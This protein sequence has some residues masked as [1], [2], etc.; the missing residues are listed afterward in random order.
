[1]SKPETIPAILV[2]VHTVIDCATGRPE[3]P[4]KTVRMHA[5]QLTD[6]SFVVDRLMPGNKCDVCLDIGRYYS[7]FPYPVHFYL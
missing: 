5:Y 2:G 3:E 7:N 1:M 6:D 4:I